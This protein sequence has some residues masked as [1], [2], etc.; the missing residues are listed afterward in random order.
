V[1]VAEAPGPTNTGVAQRDIA[2]ADS[3]AVPPPPHGPVR[4]RGMGAV[5]SASNYCGTEGNLGGVLP[6]VSGFPCPPF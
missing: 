3:T 5:F 1:R 4:S 6:K 2:S